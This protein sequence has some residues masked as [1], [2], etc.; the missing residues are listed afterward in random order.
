MTPNHPHGPP[1]TL[2]NMR[3]LGVQNLIA[4][5]LNDACRHSGTDRRVEL[6][7]RDRG[8]V[9]FKSPGEVRQ[10]RRPGQQDRRAAKLERAASAAD[11]AALRIS[12]ENL[13]A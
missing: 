8:A 10:V 6:S 1:M 12:R 5:C 9:G 3:E 11:Q 13:A 7:G 4:F 2:G